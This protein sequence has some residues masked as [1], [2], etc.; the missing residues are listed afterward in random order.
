MQKGQI[1]TLYQR[2]LE[3][4]FPPRQE[5]PR[6]IGDID[7]RLL[8]GDI[9]SYVESCLRGQ[10]DR[11]RLPVLAERCAEAESVLPCMGGEAREFFER[12]LTLALAVYE[13]QVA[14]A[15]QSAA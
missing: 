11:R 4:G 7:L 2:H 14:E 9:A 8:D 5:C 13:W 1:A 6:V 3:S 12:A 15:T 10:F